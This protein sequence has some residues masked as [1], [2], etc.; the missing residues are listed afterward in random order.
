MGRGGGRSGLARTTLGTPVRVWN[1]PTDVD[2]VSFLVAR[3]ESNFLL[4]LRLEAVLMR[5]LLI[6]LR[7]HGGGRGNVRVPGPQRAHVCRWCGW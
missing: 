6:L 2:V 3:Q 7:A 1:F 4:D 5:N